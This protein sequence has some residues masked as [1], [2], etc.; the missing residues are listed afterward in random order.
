MMANEFSEL[1]AVDFGLGRT[2]CAAFDGLAA[3]GPADYEEF[4]GRNSNKQVFRHDFD[5]P[6][7][8]ISSYVGGRKGSRVVDP[9]TTANVLDLPLV[10]YCRKPGITNN[11]NR[12]IIHD[13]VRWDEDLETA[14][15]LSVFPLYLQYRMIMLSWDKPT[16]DKLQLAW[17]AYLTKRRS[18]NHVFQVAYLIDGSPLTVNAFIQEPRAIE[19]TD[20]SL[21]KE[22]G[23]VFGVEYTLTVASQVL[24]GEAVEVGDV[25]IHFRLIGYCGLEVPC[26]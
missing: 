11:E 22:E 6:Q 15:R 7:D 12:G 9:N 3:V 25:E 24:F 26:G 13:K 16:L 14:F 20:I 5:T 21:T 23:R 4:L 17:Y 2:I 8:F 1:Q 18:K 19:T 10:A